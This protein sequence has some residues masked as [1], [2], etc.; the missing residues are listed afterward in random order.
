MQWLEIDQGFDTEVLTSKSTEDSAADY[1]VGGGHSIKPRLE[2]E[3]LVIATH[4]Q[5]PLGPLSSTHRSVYR[6]TTW[7]TVT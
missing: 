3:I 6:A 2:L 5:P 4:D 7:G 1:P